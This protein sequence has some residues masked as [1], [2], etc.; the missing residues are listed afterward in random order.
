MAN[1]RPY[2]NHLLQSSGI[3]PAC[4]EEERLAAEDLAQIFRNHGF[5]PELQEFSASGSKKIV[6]AVLGV[7]V[8]LGALL[9]GI[10]GA[11]GFIGIL[12]AIAGGVLFT[13]ERMGK[14]SLSSIGAAG[15][16]QNVIAYHKA[17]G[18]L[19]S[20]RNRPVVVVAHYDSPRAD[21]LSQMPYAA[22]RPLIVKLLPYA[23][24]APAVISIVRLL[25]LPGALKVVLWVLAIV[26]AL[27][28]LAAAVATF[29]NR[30]VLPYTSGAVCNKSSVAAM[31]GV[32]NAVAPFKGDKEFPADVPFKKYM[33]EQRRAAEAAARAAA[34][35]AAA[36]AAAKAAKHGEP[37]EDVAAAGVA[38]A[39][40]AAVDEAPEGAA[41]DAAEVAEAALGATLVGAA[42][43]AIAEGIANADE[44]PEV[45]GEAD[46]FAEETAETEGL[47]DD[48]AY[49]EADEEPVEEPAPVEAAPAEPSILNAAGNYR[50]GEETI[51]SLGMVSKSC[52]LEYEE[53]AVPE[54]VAE[55]APA[56]A[57]APVE[58][59][60]EQETEAEAS[61]F[62]EDEVAD[63]ADV[64]A[65][66]YTDDEEDYLGD[67]YDDYD[68][69]GHGSY[70]DVN[71]N[72]EDAGEDEDDDYDGEFSDFAYQPSAYDTNGL[73]RFGGG[74]TGIA[75]ALSAV[76]A[77]ASRFF[78][79]ALNRGREALRN[80]EDTA[81]DMAGRLGSSA[82]RVDD[83]ADERSELDEQELFSDQT[84]GF[85]NDEE[86]LE[87]E[88]VSTA[89]QP[90]VAYEA[91]PDTALSAT[92]AIDTAPE[93]SS[94]GQTTESTAVFTP[95]STED[96]GDVVDD[97]VDSNLSAETVEDALPEDES[98]VAT[99]ED[100]AGEDYAVD[101]SADGGPVN[102]DSAVEISMTSKVSEDEPEDAVDP[103]DPP[104]F[105]VSS[106]VSDDTV[107]TN[108]D[109]STGPLLGETV[110]FTTPSSEMMS[111]AAGPASQSAPV[112][113]SLGDTMDALVAQLDP[114][115]MP[116]Q[117]PSMV[118]PDPQHPSLN[119]PV[120]ASR[121]SLFDLPDP[122]APEVDPFAPQSATGSLPAVARSEVP[123]KRR[124]FN[125]ID[126]AAAPSPTP[127]APVTAPA[128][129]TGAFEVISS[130]APMVSY[131]K[132]EKRRG[133][134]GLFRRKKK[135][136]SSMSEY[137]GVDD[138]FDAK[139]S[140]R[141]IGS[142]ENFEDDGWKG[143]AA[144]AAGV[145]ADELRDAV[146]SLGDD[147]LL[148]HDIWFVATGASEYGNAGLEAFLASHR[149]KLRGVFLIN[150]ECVGAGQ[151][152]MLATEGDRRV[153]KGD[154][155]IMNLVSR[156]SSAL[157]H[158]I[159][160]VEMPYL[161][162]DAY[163][164]MNMS[165]RS[166]TIAGVEGSCL[167]CSHSEED[168]PINLDVDN[169]NR[170]AD[171]VTEVIRR[172]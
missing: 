21:L 116:R 138:D 121:S 144:G 79:D 147:E 136:E 65:D 33:R 101:E 113:P 5:E 64:Y 92:E 166:L 48:A 165:L 119:Q 110:A 102:G 137:L 12:L 85:D 109:A 141:N 97:E 24:L 168:L 87:D 55:P 94:V 161:A 134:G 95:V 96:D 118:I 3:T 111:T 107:T 2:I 122:S 98:Y 31:L 62:A 66:A 37:V 100:L 38:T 148:G 17:S 11:I 40:V 167:A 120:V 146:T 86:D 52:V 44:A 128:T 82:E 124:S 59:E 99:A 160:S 129:A 143:G 61:D 68:D 171:V 60:A 106:E 42:A 159:G 140:G 105:E 51:R 117:R 53:P 50:F 22:Y 78:G 39:D 112:A 88:E 84:I 91:I 35:A 23:M 9:M 25:P 127:S 18:P 164:A 126:P 69:D 30:F 154:K 153:L 26:A 20:P 142:W 8:F 56:P 172:S 108:E 36:E 47:Y 16:S 156:V 157:H 1:V 149:D 76:G 80:L 27:V 14:T 67:D 34:E 57:P 93:L 45:E 132:E 130:D 133:L 103:M 46:A 43:G 131:Q 104:S 28:P 58:N 81:R 152:A 162:T 15:L 158:E 74:A 125:V 75:G 114:S 90:T 70:A 170:V 89:D 49:D 135:D 150:L 29:A 71:D 63:E 19:A 115:D 10:G 151:L 139:R 32:M 54:P 41:A 6:N 73:A 72:F 155:R 83:Y 145:G 163:A 13:L 169:I 123:G 77:G 7:L 4:S